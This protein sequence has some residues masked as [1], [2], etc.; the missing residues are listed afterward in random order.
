MSRVQ[1]KDSQEAFGFFNSWEEYYREIQKRSAVIPPSF[2]SARYL[3]E[4]TPDLDF[5]GSDDLDE[6]NG[7]IKDF[8]DVN[9]LDSIIDNVKDLFST[10]SLGGAFDKDR[11]IATAMPIGIFDFSLASQG[12]YKPQEYY[13]PDLDKLINPDLVRTINKNPLIFVYYGKDGYDFK[14]YVL[15]QQQEGTY[16]VGKKEDYIKKLVK[17]GT[18]LKLAKDMAKKEFPNCRLVFRTTTKKVYLTRASNS[19]ADNESGGEKYVDILAPIGGLAK[20]TPRSLMYSVMP[21]LLLVYFLN[22]AGIKTRVLGTMQSAKNDNI[23]GGAIRD[24]YRGFESFVI[25]DYDE[26]LDFNK[27]AIL[28]ADSR[29]FR[30]KIFEGIAGFYNDKFDEDIGSGL[31][32]DP[33]GVN[34]AQM[35]ERYKSWYVSEISKGAKIFN[36]NKRLMFMSG[37]VANPRDSDDVLLEKAKDE[38]F[39]ILDAI[40]LEFNGATVSFPRIR[41]RDEKRGIDPNSIRSRLQGT[42]ALATVY[43]ESDSKYTSTDADI[44]KKQDL[45][46]KLRADVNQVMSQQN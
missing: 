11:F 24:T 15:T 44:K 18:D 39:K 36:K 29:I 38:F 5:V 23:L 17:G 34:R 3:R 8:A 42:I 31:G 32:Q 2:G 20:Q 10:I 30:W 14:A 43:D 21:S 25:K 46:R 37:F 40:D 28:T 4:R 16:C 45:K 1:N 26:T 9:A 27:V 33:T 7:D 13:S 12:L 41:E 19:L 35:F 22:N 6:L